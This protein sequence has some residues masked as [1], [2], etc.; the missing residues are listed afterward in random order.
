[1]NFTLVDL[2]SSVLAIVAFGFF[3]LPP[4]YL[5]AHFTNLAG[6][7]KRTRAEQLLWVSGLSLPLSL[8]LCAVVGRFLSPLALT[9][10]YAGSALLAFV[11]GFPQIWRD[12]SFVVKRLL[13]YKEVLG[14]LLL[15]VGY[16]LLVTT[17]VEVH[18]HLYESV[19]FTDWSVRLPMVNAAMR[20]GVP[21]SNPFFTVNGHPQPSRYYYYWYVLCAAVGRPLHLSARA[22]L[23][24]S[25]VWS[26]LALIAVLFLFLKHLLRYSP[27]TPRHYLFPLLLCCVMGVDVL[28][29]ILGYLLKPPVIYPEIEWWLD[30]R[31]PSFAGAVIFAPHHIAGVVCCC[32]AFLVFFLSRAEWA[33]QRGRRVRETQMVAVVTGAICFA[34]CAGDSTFVAFCFGVAGILYTL[35]LFR[36]KRWAEIAVL[37]LAAALSVFWSL[38]FLRELLRETPTLTAEH[39]RVLEFALRNR[40]EKEH[41]AGSVLYNMHGFPRTFLYVTVAPVMLVLQFG[42]LLIPLLLRVRSDVRRWRAGERMSD[43]ER[44]LWVIFLG[45]ALPGFFLSSAPQGVN[46]L[47]RHA[48]LIMRLVLIVW[49]VPLLW[50]YFQRWGERKPLSPAHP[51][52]ARIAVSF[53]IVG[54]VSQMWQITVDR[55]LL[56]FLAHHPKVTPAAPLAHEDDAGARFY[57][58][59]RGLSLVEARLPPEAVVQSNMTGPF[60]MIVMFYSTHPFAAGDRA[61]VTSFGGDDTACLAITKDLHTLFYTSPLISYVAAA[62]YP[63]RMPSNVEARYHKWPPVDPAEATPDVFLK[64]CEREKLAAVVVQNSDL[65]WTVPTSWVWQLQPLYAGSLVRIF[66]CPAYFPGE[67]IGRGGSAAAGQAL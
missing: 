16:V 54:L 36:E 61:C 59:R 11:V 22:C 21:P 39:H 57:Q 20:D 5:F 6:F 23:S 66:G 55:G 28:A 34:A 52:F 17:S 46:D 42:F 50:P 26:G 53:F 60:Q 27:R 58:L 19:N 29:A 15:F 33:G 24:A 38:P 56:P 63:S 47:G 13:Y 7:R 12:R 31:I 32:M 45:A 8:F 35:I 30:D 1:M 62:P 25:A 48:G 44:F 2:F 67:A 51:W 9:S 43:G 40:R 37:V 41:F 64:A 65:V 10:L 3:L 4:A 14:A 49:A 18:K